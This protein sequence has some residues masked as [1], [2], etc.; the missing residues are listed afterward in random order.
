MEQQRLIVLSVLVGVVAAGSA[1]FGWELYENLAAAC[2]R[3]RERRRAAAEAEAIT[4]RE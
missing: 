3:A 2:R 4:R 1:W